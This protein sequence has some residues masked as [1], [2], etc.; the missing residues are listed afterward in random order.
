MQKTIT[1]RRMTPLTWVFAAICSLLAFISISHV[2]YTP[3]KGGITGLS[4]HIKPSS[5]SSVNTTDLSSILYDDTKEEAEHRPLIL[6]VYSETVKPNSPFL[7]ADNATSKGR[8]NILFFINHALHAEA[9]FIFILNGP[10]TIEPFIPT[11]KPNIKI[12]R[13]E[14]KCFD[15]GAYADVLQRNDG[16]LMKKYKRFIMMN[17]SV[18]GPFMP[19]WSRECWSDAMLAKLTD[20]NKLVGLSYNCRKIRHIQSMLLATDS[21]GISLIMPKINQC[22]ESFMK[23][24]GGEI[25]ITGAVTSQGYNVTALM[26]SFQSSK[27]YANTCKHGDILL[28]NRYYNITMHP[29][30]TMFQKANRGMAPEV[31]ERLTEWIDGSG[32]DSWGVCRRARNVRRVVRE[33]KRRGVDLDFGM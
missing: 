23:A 31:L 15:L 17:G 10:T 2:L 19:S 6:Y 28:N 5:S 8:Q 18:R 14:N 7:T 20:T 12:V 25:S 11:H 21:I 4:N 27:D 13:R 30:E 22:F 16:E 32:Y 24:I 1:L 29:F 26:T 3:S 9:D 33:M